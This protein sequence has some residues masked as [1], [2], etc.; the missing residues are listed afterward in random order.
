MD[1]IT[2]FYVI[3]TFLGRD[4]GYVSWEGLSGLFI[5]G[6]YLIVL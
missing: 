4:F 1:Q 6:H 5:E 2:D 3:K